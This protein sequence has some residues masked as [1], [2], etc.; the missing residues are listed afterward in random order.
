MA[1]GKLRNTDAS[2]N[3]ISPS[4]N[5]GFKGSEMYTTEFEINETPPTA[6]TLLT[7]G[8]IQDEINGF[9]GATVSTRGRFMTESEKQRCTNE[10]PLYLYIQGHTKRNIDMAIQKINEII[11]TEHRSSLNRPSRF[12]NAPPPLMSLHSGVPS[13]EKICVGIENA[14][15]GFGL[16]GRIIG[17]GGSNLLY[18]RGETGAT[19]TL[20]GRGSQFI[21][22]ALG[23]ESPEPLHLYIEHPN[24]PVLQNAKQL[25]INL[26]QTMQSELQSY[27]Q[28]QPPPVQS[29]QVMPQPQI[30]QIQQAQ[31]QTMNIGAVGQPNV[32]TIQHQDIIQHPQNSV[33]TLP[34]TILT[35]TVAGTPGPGMHSGPMQPTDHAQQELQTFVP[36]PSVSQVQLIGPP[37]TISQVQYQIHPGQPLQIQGL[38][39][40][41][42]SPSQPVTQMYVMSQPPPQSPIHQGFVSASSAPPAAVSYVYTQPSLQRSSTPSRVIETVNVNLQQ[43]PPPPPPPPANHHHHHPPPSLLHLH[44]PPPFPPN[45]PPPPIP[46]TYQIQYQQVPASVSQGQTQFVLQTSGEPQQLD[47]NHEQHRIQ[48][49]GQPPPH[50]HLH[51]PPPP[52]P[53]A[54]GTGQT[55]LVQETSSTQMQQ[56]PLPDVH[57]RQEIV[58]S[59]PPQPVPPPRMVPPPPTIDSIQHSVNMLTSVPPPTHAPPPQAPWLY[60]GQ[61]IPVA[62]SQPQLQMQIPAPNLPPPEVQAQMHYH[63]QQVQYHNGQI[64]AQVH[65]ALQPPHH[66]EPKPELSDQHKLQGVKRRFSDLEGVE[67]S[68]IHPGMRPP[69]QRHGMGDEDRH[70][71]VLHSSPSAAGLGPSSDD[72]VKPHPSTHPGDKRNGD[73]SM[74]AVTSGQEN[75]S[76]LDPGNS[77]G[78]GHGPV[79]L[80]LP[81]PQGPWPGN[82]AR[83][84][85]ARPPAPP[86]PREEHHPHYRAP[87]PVNLPPPRLRM[88]RGPNDDS[89]SVCQI[90]IG[91]QPIEYEQI[92]SYSGKPLPN[93]P[94]PLMHSICDP[95]PPPPPPPVTPSVH[96]AQM[97]P[98]HH[99]MQNAHHYQQP[100]VS[101]AFQPPT[102]CPPWMN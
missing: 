48:F 33:V 98:Q 28:Q 75:V 64:Q 54:G 71:A 78:L 62:S 46:Q 93:N 29:Q 38:P 101:H 27:I 12:T 21:D 30:Q 44:F 87:P 77:S 11:K 39:P 88:I 31:F 18:I 10:R 36:P 55:Y 57:Q 79:S 3:K 100:P 102:G 40:C 22:P 73:Q 1:K 32:V 19:V 7:K 5:G 47:Q 86:G 51:G 25:A 8:F 94:L 16:R 6:R 83:I 2:N 91:E 17:A 59:A 81:A 68:P 72:R 23:T 35:A 45:Q 50:I 90:G 61:Q 70:R 58:Q 53:G 14:P 41:S 63:A 74:G 15:E 20:R 95:P 76:N 99:L 34:A 4:S 89:Q 80:P 42:E 84:P 92:Q 56:P 65:Y 85:Y 13:V 49:E 9:S 24:P 97:R 52:P 37:P 82:F 96:G 69:S 66:M 26:I 60:Q 67:E 43:P